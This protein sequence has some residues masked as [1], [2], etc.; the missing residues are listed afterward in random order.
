MMLLSNP[1]S[2]ASSAPEM[3]PTPW[4]RIGQDMPAGAAA[5][6]IRA[7]AFF[8]GHGGT[9]AEFVLGVWIAAAVVMLTAGWLRT[10]KSKP[11]QPAAARAPKSTSSPLTSA[12]QASWTYSKS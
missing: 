6:L 1:L 3:L 2:A 12:S 10:R 9:H 11:D 8:H 5:S 4:G 7:T